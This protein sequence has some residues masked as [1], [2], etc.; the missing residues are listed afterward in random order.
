MPQLA[1]AIVDEQAV[2]VIREWIESLKPSDS[3]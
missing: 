1:T 2:A 3:N